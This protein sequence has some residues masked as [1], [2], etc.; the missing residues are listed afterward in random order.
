MV[1]KRNPLMFRGRMKIARWRFNDVWNNPL[2]YGGYITVLNEP[3]VTDFSLM[4]FAI[5]I[6]QPRDHQILMIPQCVM[7]DFTAPFG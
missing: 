6:R 3:F 1:Y 2:R 7:P 5:I 4:K